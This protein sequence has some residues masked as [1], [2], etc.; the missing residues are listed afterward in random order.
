M[1]LLFFII[2]WN[3]V[4]TQMSLDHKWFLIVP[5]ISGCIVTVEAV[6]TISLLQRKK[7][8]FFKTYHLSG[9]C[10]SFIHTASWGNND[11]ASSAEGERVNRVRPLLKQ[12]I[13][14]ILAEADM[15]SY[16]AVKVALHFSHLW[17]KYCFSQAERTG[18]KFASSLPKNIFNSFVLGY[19]FAYSIIKIIMFTNSLRFL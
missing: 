9:V 12:E 2:V 17:A 16:M 3:K 8:F 15:E 11:P 18:T 14:V 13:H 4:Q 7:C 1:V 5:L 10:C 19:Y 6:C